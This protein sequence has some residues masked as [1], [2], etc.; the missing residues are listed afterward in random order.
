[1]SDGPSAED[2]LIARHFAPLATDPGAFR[3]TDDAAVITPPPGSDL[4]VTTDGV[5]AGVHFFPDDPPDKIARKVLRMNL[6]DLAAK[7]AKPVG[8]LISVSLPGNVDDAWI[9]SFAAGLGDD[10]KDYG[11]PLLG[12]DTD[13]TPG[14]IAAS[15]TA[16]GAV[17][18]G[19]MV[20]RS[21][22]KAGDSVVVTGTIGDSA[23]GVRLRRDPSLA[24][25]W[26]LTETML[27]HLQQ[28]YLLPEPRNALADAVLQYAASAMDVS[29]GLVGDIAKLG[30]ASGVAVE[31]DV[32]RVPFSQ[33]ARTAIAADPALIET[34]L[35]GGDDYEIVLTL[36]PERLAALCAA[37]DKAGVA[38]TE[39][40]RIMAGEGARFIR[41]GKPLAFTR[42]SYSH[43]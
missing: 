33:A 9:A 3:L 24:Q 11:C 10:A 34:A 13:R 40:G 28:R 43:F 31:I 25:R 23:L 35:T 29:D 41:D 30:R 32:A 16:F 14:P 22:A 12:G 5:I 17:P 21:T 8:F 37:A 27:A 19:A 2:R 4:V 20:R 38:V 26:R 18:K 42:S 15:I 36:K 39:I 6:S 7:G 1:M